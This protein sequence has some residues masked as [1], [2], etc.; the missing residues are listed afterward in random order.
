MYN[1]EL[2]KKESGTSV[3]KKVPRRYKAHVLKAVNALSPQKSTSLLASTAPVAD[4]YEV[5][6]ARAELRAALTST[7][8]RQMDEND[9]AETK[10]TYERLLAA[11]YGHSEV[12]ERLTAVLVEEIHAV[13]SDHQPFNR[14]RYAASL[15]HLE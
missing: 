3:S 6:Q 10:I 1:Q 2:A 13:L 15:A 4:P 7:I 14:A 5:M 11:G 12:M 9:P 8:Q